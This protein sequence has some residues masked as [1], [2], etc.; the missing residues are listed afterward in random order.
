MLGESLMAAGD[1]KEAVV[2]FR[3]AVRLRPDYPDSSRKL[4]MSLATL[5]RFDEPT[6]V[7]LEVKRRVPAAPVGSE[8]LIKGLSPP[9][10]RPVRL[11]PHKPVATWLCDSDA[12]QPG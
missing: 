6:Q 2:A 5:G 10:C 11:A 4:G 9:D 12:G 3:N 8:P 7:F 1:R